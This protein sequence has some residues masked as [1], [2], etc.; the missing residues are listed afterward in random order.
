MRP[1]G[2]V[3][4]A[5]PSHSFI[6]SFSKLFTLFPKMKPAVLV[7]G[8]SG[9]LGGELINSL[10]EDNV[11]VVAIS[12]N[13][14]ICDSRCNV[15][16]SDLK[17]IHLI[18]ELRTYNFYACFHFAASSS[19]PRSWVDPVDDLENGLPGTVSLIHYLSQFYPKCR[20]IVSSSAAIYGNPTNLPITEEAAIKPISPYGIHKA[21]IELLCEKY[22]QLY[23]LSIT[24]IRIFSAYGSGLR[25]QLLWDT[26]NKL[27]MATESGAKTIEMFG[28]GHETRDFIH[29]KDVASAALSILNRSGMERFSIYNVA[30]GQEVTIQSLVESIC[31]LWYNDIS[32]VFIGK[33]IPGDPNRWVADIAKLSSIG[34]KPQIGIRE[35]LIEYVEWAKEALKP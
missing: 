22:S 35:G 29:K 34:F 21:A 27:K 28:T 15:V 1:V 16:R 10:L 31:S 7:T 12:R 25:K 8:G 30:S 32:P 26:V 4:S 23:D 3:W 9:F 20:L 24:I 17:R 11:N 18:N 19:V 5:I 33:K 13:R 6:V 14:I 2:T